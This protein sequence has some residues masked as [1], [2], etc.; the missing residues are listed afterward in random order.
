M[1]P[2]TSKQQYIWRSNNLELQRKNKT[3]ENHFKAMEKTILSE[4]NYR[5]YRFSD[6]RSKNQQLTHDFYTFSRAKEI[7]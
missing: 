4:N 3:F 2:L 5:K 1:Q 7:I 6:N